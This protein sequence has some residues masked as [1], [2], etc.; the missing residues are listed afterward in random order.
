MLS[1]GGTT[2]YY[3]TV[4]FFQSSEAFQCL[5]DLCAVDEMP[6]AIALIPVQSKLIGKSDYLTAV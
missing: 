6:K 1:L 5:S 2:D 3:F 4:F